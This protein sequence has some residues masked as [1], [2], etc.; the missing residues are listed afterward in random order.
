MREEDNH[1]HT[2]TNHSHP[3]TKILKKT[4]LVTCI[5]IIVNM[6][7]W[8][9]FIRVIY[10]WKYSQTLLQANHFNEITINQL[11]QNNLS[12]YFAHLLLKYMS[13]IQGREMSG[14][15]GFGVLVVA[16]LEKWGCLTGR[17]S[18]K[19]QGEHYTDLASI[20]KKKKK[21]WEMESYTFF[22]TQKNRSS[23]H[24]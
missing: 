1:S 13:T 18:P 21:S 9:I 5:W 8:S 11:K 19:N 3:H 23:Q 12:N 16:G 14:S 17:E 10:E 4:S 6:T 24:F 7:F 15:C 2:A 20:W 22:V